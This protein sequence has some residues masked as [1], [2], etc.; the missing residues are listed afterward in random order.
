LQ[1]RNGSNRTLIIGLGRDNFKQQFA[2]DVLKG[3][4]ESP[5]YLYSKYFYDDIGSRLFEEIMLLPEYY[6]TRSEFEIFSIQSPQIVSAIA[7][8]FHVI[9]LGPGNG[10]K[11]KLFLKEAIRQKKLLTYYPIDISREALDGLKQNLQAEI[12]GSIQPIEN[13]YMAGIQSLSDIPGNKLILFMGSNIGNL[14]HAETVAFFSTLS[15]LMR[16]GDHF[17]IGFDLKKDPELIRSAYNDA[18]GITRAFNLNL[19][20][21][22]NRELEANIDVSQFKHY[23]TYD[24][25]TGEARSYLISQKDQI[26]RIGSLNKEFYFHQHE[27]I[28]MEVSRKYEIKEMENYATLAGLNRVEE[29]R[30]C[31][32]YFA[33]VLFK[34]S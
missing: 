12:A 7:Q 21:R 25:I 27:A 29:F 8:P 10:L 24:P 28:Y 17:L 19:L 13:E 1:I 26:V 15:P 9:E 5:K 2:Q 22:I 3:F 31:K 14:S 33:D 18:F 23:P 16:K 4:S 11:T 32:A 6:L 34:K 20:H 30:D